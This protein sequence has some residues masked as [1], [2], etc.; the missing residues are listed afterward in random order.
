MRR[1]GRSGAG[2][3]V[4][5]ELETI[6]RFTRSRATATAPPRPQ[7][8]TIRSGLIVFRRRSC[9]ETIAVE[10]TDPAKELRLLGL[11]FLGTEVDGNVITGL[12]TAIGLDQDSPDFL[13][14][15]A[16]VQ[17]RVREVG[18]LATGV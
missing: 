4:P 3:D 13:E 14:V 15:L 1:C 5:R 18:S 11:H 12:S 8:P 17:R 9:L 7:Q 10:M 6:R 2:L 16:I